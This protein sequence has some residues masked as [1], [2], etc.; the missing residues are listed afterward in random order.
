M[1]NI[2]RTAGV[3]LGIGLAVLT[4]S[5]LVPLFG[6]FGKATAAYNVSFSNIWLSKV[7]PGSGRIGVDI[8]WPSNGGIYNP[9]QNDN[10]TYYGA[11]QL[12][13]SAT[14]SYYK[15]ANYTS[16]STDFPY[17][18]FIDNQDPNYCT[19]SSWCKNKTPGTFVHNWSTFITNA[20]V[21]VYPYDSGNQY[22]PSQDNVGGVRASVGFPGF[23]NGGRYSQPLGTINLPQLGQSNVGKLNGYVTNNGTTV[24]SGRVTI[25]AFQDDSSL[26]SSTGYPLNGF[27]S[28][29]NNSAGYY[30]T[31]ALPDGIYKLYVDDTQTNHTIILDNINITVPYARLDFKLDQRCFGYPNSYCTDPAS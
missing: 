2:S 23:A 12:S 19:S 18:I 4:L 28:V 27:S 10:D 8:W 26:S 24:S 11:C 5:V 7:S 21:E 13:N 17:G 22:D 20:S 29:Q 25:S 31:G 1:I 30:T 16:S 9:C 14:T 3:K 6:H 15:I